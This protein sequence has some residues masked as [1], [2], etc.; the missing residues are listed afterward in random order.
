MK[1]IKNSKDGIALIIVLGMLSML[2]VWAVA[3]SIS[4]RMERL[5]AKNYV[6]EVHAKHFLQTAL[7]AAIQGID[8]SMIGRCYP[9]QNAMCSM[10]TNNDFCSDILIGKASNSISC[11]LWADAISVTNNCRWINIISTNSFNPDAKSTNGRVAYLVVNC[12]GLL[13]ANYLGDTN[14]SWCTNIVNA[15]FNDLA[16]Y[17]Y[18]DYQEHRRYETISELTALK[19]AKPSAVSNL[20]IYSYDVNRDMYFTNRNELGLRNITLTTKF[21][22][23]SITNY[24]CYD[25]C[26]YDAYSSELENTNSDFKINYWDPLTNLLAR[27]E[28]HLA[29]PAEIAWNIINYLDEDRIPQNS[30]KHPWMD[31][32]GSEA[33][34][35][36]NEVVL[37][38]IPSP[39]TNHYE[40]VVELWYPF[41]PLEVKD[42]EFELQV[43]VSDENLETN[44]CSS[45][46]DI[47]TF[48]AGNNWSFKKENIGEM[49]FGAEDEFLCFTSPPISFPNITTNVPPTTNY[50]PISADNSVWFLARVLKDNI[51]VDQ[52]MDQEAIEFTDTVGYSV[53]DPRD[54]GEEERWEDPY[55]WN[56]TNTTFGT[57]NV[58]CKPSANHGQGLPIYHRDGPMQNIGELGQIYHSTVAVGIPWLN[59]NIM[60]TQNRSAALLDYMTVRATNEQ[61]SMHGLIN[62]NT[63]NPDVLRAL[64]HNMKIGYT[65]EMH[66]VNTN[67]INNLVSTII[68]NKNWPYC[69]FQD[70]FAGGKSN[71][72]AEAFRACVPT[73]DVPS[74]DY[75]REAGLRNILD[76]IT[77]R[78]N[79]FTIILVAQVL[80]PDGRTP[81]AEKRAVAIVYRDVYTGQSFVRLFM[82]LAD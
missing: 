70:M 38:K 26:D 12:S 58:N 33:V 48:S 35:L 81:V 63:K 40:F 54:N 66:E 68:T 37:Q 3:F 56:S 18:K 43:A 11:S 49:E 1:T 14:H 23:N 45:T 34:P 44:I 82:P 42:D 25:S 21:C 36:I 50:L 47:T 79:I 77:F 6:N 19:D 73:N 4:M 5:S 74:T 69:N 31:K 46:N 28:V 61:S 71:A 75:L 27:D 30:G 39:P 53:N 16:D 20:F 2:I 59:I 57:T 80:S 17:F 60:D 29:N 24:A 65:N 76:K 32:A 62:I 51:P 9:D 7:A 10:N 8:N 78:Q 72:V 15:V 64:F 13:D 41:Y 55:A 52:A 22:V 67:A